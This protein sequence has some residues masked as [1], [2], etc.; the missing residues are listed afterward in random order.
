[1]P[2]RI[3]R[4]VLYI[5]RK[6]LR[7]CSPVPSEPKEKRQSEMNG[8]DAGSLL[9]A[10]KYARNGHFSSSSHWGLV[11]SYMYKLSSLFS[12]NSTFLLL[13]ILL[14]TTLLLGISLRLAILRLMLS[15]DIMPHVLQKPFILMIRRLRPRSS[16]TSNIRL[17]LLIVLPQVHDPLGILIAH[18]IR[19]HLNNRALVDAQVLRHLH[20]ELHAQ[21]TFAAAAVIEFLHSHAGKGNLVASAGSSGDFNFDVAVKRRDGD[22]ASEHGGR[23]RNGSCVKDVGAITAEFVVG[24]H[25]DEDV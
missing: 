21:I 15:R 16:I 17:R 23:K 8:K 12:Y 2:L 25:A 7:K 10:R 24:R 18:L 3:C 14:L 9:A 1:M 6:A 5:Q 19:Q 4:N 20:L 11:S 22:F 13:L